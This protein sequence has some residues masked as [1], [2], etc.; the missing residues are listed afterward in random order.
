[1]KTANEICPTTT[2]G[3]VKEGALLVDV[4]EKSE[5]AQLAFDVPNI[6][7]IPFSEFEERYNEIPKDRE[8]ILVC[9]VG[10]R[11]LKTAYYLLNQGYEEANV[12]NMQY[13]LNRWVDKGFPTTGDTTFATTENSGSCCSPATESTSETTSCC[14]PTTKESGATC[15]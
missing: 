8:V 14:E 15:C 9:M 4:R 10:E 3:R 12:A 2:M 13:G 1:M 5:V 6:I 7:N 11:S